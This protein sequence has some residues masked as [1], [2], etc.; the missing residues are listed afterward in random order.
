MQNGSSDTQGDLLGDLLIVDDLADNL[1]VLSNTLMNQGYRVRCV[2]NGQM[3]LV[4]VR[5]NPPDVILLDIRMPEMDGYEV[6]RQLKADPQTCEIPIIFLSAL[7]EVEDKTRAFQVG[8][9]DYIIKPFPVEEVLTRVKNQLMIQ[10]LKRQVAEQRERLAELAVLA[11]TIP[12]LEAT[13]PIYN[14]AIAAIATILD[15]S[16]RLCQNPAI[17]AEQYAAL[18]VIHQNGQH[19]LDLVRSK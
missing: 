1:R 16:A 6:C 9:A 4:G 15:Y 13:N 10:K 19:L 5:A 17:N 2:R 12:T 14:D 3:A 7:D 8:G 11:P 18:K